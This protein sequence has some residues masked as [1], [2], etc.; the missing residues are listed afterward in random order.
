MK[1]ELGG[2]AMSAKAEKQTKRKF[3]VPNT[4][5]L[6]MLFIILAAIATYIVPAGE[7]SMI[8]DPATGKNAID[9]TSFNF[10]EQN[11]VSVGDFLLSIP[12]GMNGG[13]AIIFLVF[14]V[15]GFFQIVNDTGAVDAAI[16]LSINKLQNK[17]LLVIPII[18]GIMSILGAVGIVVNA[19]IAFVPIGVA[20]AKKLKLDP[21]AGVAIMYLGA[22]SGFTSSPMGPF[23]TVLG[24][25]IAGL[26]PLSGFGFRTAV[27]LTIFIVTV[28]YTFRY[29]KKLRLDQSNSV[30][31]EIDWGDSDD[32]QRSDMKFT[33]RH[34]LVLVALMT[35]F[36]VYAYGSYKL[37]WGLSYLSAMMLAVALVS[38]LVAKMHP[39]DMAKSFIKGAQRMVYG[40]LVIGFAKCITLLLTEGQVIHSVIYYMTIPLTKV[41]PVFSALGMF[42]ANLFFNFVV[43]S[44]SGQAMIVMPLM[45]P[46]ADV[47]N[48]S[49]QIAVSAYQ[50]GD[51]FSNIMIPTSGVL[52]AVLG[53]AKIPYEKWLKF[54][55]PLFSLWVLI[56]A[57]SIVIATLIGWA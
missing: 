48:V 12:K 51:G 2:K 6:I 25:T 50:Y 32:D 55:L 20:L 3:R 54:V 22:F 39:D 11:P 26:P 43:P 8:K 56:G 40:A 57:I 23:N 14:L 53:V 41:A 17:A 42:L 46:M 29:A 38:G 13:A 33:A 10:V 1:D 47:V 27:W 19:A 34:A 9:P 35:G 21:I 49:R 30:L 36:V 37:K 31:E 5:T 7:Y 45:A 18:M 44:G 52:M 24:Q 4:Y 16:N 15:G 28:W